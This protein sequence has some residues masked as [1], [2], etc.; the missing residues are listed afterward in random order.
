M[1]RPEIVFVKFSTS[2]IFKIWLL[3]LLLHA[4][5][6]LGSCVSLSIFLFDLVEFCNFK[7]QP[8][9]IKLIFFK[10]CTQICDHNSKFYP[11]N[12]LSNRQK[13]IQFKF[14]KKYNLN[15]GCATYFEWKAILIFVNSEKVAQSFGLLIT[16]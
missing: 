8:R 15:Q 4:F 5:I 2:N 14:K 10:F 9:S 3:F 13:K 11:L 12:E 16:K 1:A 7:F 6:W